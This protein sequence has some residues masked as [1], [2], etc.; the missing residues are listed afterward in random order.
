MT[1][2]VFWGCLFTAFGP[3]A[4]MVVLT[5][6][7]YPLRVILLV[8][9]AFFWLFSLLLTSLLWLAVVPLREEAAFGLFIGVMLQEILRFS[10]LKL[11]QK[12]DAGLEDS[13]SEEE[14]KS[15]ARHR[16]PYVI[17][18]GFGLMSGSFSILNL[19]SLAHGPGNVGINGNSSNF[20]L[21]SALLTNAFVLLNTF[22]TIIVHDGLSK[23][24]YSY[25][26]IVIISHFLLSGLTLLNT[27]GDLYLVSV[28]FSYFLLFLTMS[29]SFKIVGGS[30]N[31]L[32]TLISSL[33]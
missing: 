30:L 13:L 25:V 22:W 9:G 6:A 10:M 15:I 4:S 28:F 33:C 23:R 29:W 16:L 17:G 24:K 20:F 26:I 14:K 11:M 19:L 12:A 18:L 31:N 1:S 2:L 27:D 32:R 21:M 5:I 8:V 3:A 7:K